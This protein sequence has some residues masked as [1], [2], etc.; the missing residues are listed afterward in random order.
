MQEGD[1]GMLTS[2]YYEKKKTNYL[3]YNLLGCILF[4]LY[5]QQHTYSRNLKEKNTTYIKTAINT[6]SQKKPN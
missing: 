1:F 4:S 2:Q 6:L 3:I 5:K